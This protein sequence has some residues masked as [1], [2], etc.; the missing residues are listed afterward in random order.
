MDT[1]APATPKKRVHYRKPHTQT[2]PLKR[3]DGEP[4]VRSLRASLL[5]DPKVRGMVVGAIAAGAPYSVAASIAYA[6]GFPVTP[7]MIAGKKRDDPAFAD[8]LDQCASRS[9]ALVALSLYRKATSGQDTTAMIFWLKNRQPHLWRDRKELEVN[10]P[11]ITGTLRLAA[12]AARERKRALLELVKKDAIDVEVEGAIV[13]FIPGGNGN[14][15][16]GNGHG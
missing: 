6:Q 12:D 2:E 14:G 8:E 1:P 15:N 11:D 10:I 5:D 9:D 13:P 7:D 3:Q 4:D 16:G